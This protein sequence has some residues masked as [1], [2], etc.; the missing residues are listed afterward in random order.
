[1]SSEEEILVYIVED[2]PGNR[3]HNRGTGTKVYTKKHH[4]D[5]LCSRYGDRYKVV[6]YK[7][8]KVEESS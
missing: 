4:A 5:N 1:M 2:T 7:L 8:V 3:A 6:T